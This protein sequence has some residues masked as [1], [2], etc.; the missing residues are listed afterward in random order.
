MASNQ[1]EMYLWQRSFSPKLLPRY[2]GKCVK[3]YSQLCIG[4]LTM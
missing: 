3:S 2:M 1:E 4:N